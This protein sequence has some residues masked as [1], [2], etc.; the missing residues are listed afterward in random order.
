MAFHNGPPRTTRSN[1]SAEPGITREHY[2]LGPKNIKRIFNKLMLQKVSRN[3]YSDRLSRDYTSEMCKLR[4]MEHGE[5]NGIGHKIWEQ[6]HKVLN[7]I[8]DSTQLLG[9]ILVAP[10]LPDPNSKVDI[11][12][13][14]TIEYS[15]VRQYNQV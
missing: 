7:S 8:P 12:Q 2:Q 14:Q 11:P 3:R 4:N 13:S 6:T 9:M 5:L 15:Q 1:L 10:E